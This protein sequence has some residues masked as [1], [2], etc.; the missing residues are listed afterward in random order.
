[1]KPKVYVFLPEEDRSEEGPQNQ[2]MLFLTCLVQNFFPKD[3]SVLWLQNGQ[4][5]NSSQYSTTAPTKTNSSPPSFFTVS[6]LEVSR[7]EWM[8]SN[9]FTCRVVH[10]ALP[11]P[12]TLEKTVSKSPGK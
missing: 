12:R 3:I 2:D 7:T 1:M 4:K 9:K 10:E 6:R 5:I 11:P 8:K